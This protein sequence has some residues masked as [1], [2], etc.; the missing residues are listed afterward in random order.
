MSNNTDGFFSPEQKQLA[1]EIKA[2]I[3]AGEGVSL[4]ELIK[5]LSHNERTARGLVKEQNKPSD[6][7]FF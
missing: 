2:K 5:L 3:L 7:D 6:V 4:G 1:L